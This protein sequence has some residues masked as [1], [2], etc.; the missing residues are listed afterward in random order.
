MDQ[1]PHLFPRETDIV[2]PCRIRTDGRGRTV[3]D[4]LVGCAVVAAKQGCVL[5][6]TEAPE[7][8]RKKIS[9]SRIQKQR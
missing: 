8:P 4:C 6:G 1:R 5:F 9:L 2:K 7:A 3:L